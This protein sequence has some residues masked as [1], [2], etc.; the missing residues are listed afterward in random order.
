MLRAYFALKKGIVVVGLIY[1]T[2]WSSRPKLAK[3][4]VNRTRQNVVEIIQGQTR[5]V[6]E[7][8]RSKVSVI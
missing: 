8:M 6:V 2:L 3:R 1:L 7:V 5:A 4:N